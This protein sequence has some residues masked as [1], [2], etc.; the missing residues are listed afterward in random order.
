MYLG[1]LIQD[2][3]LV[4]NAFFAVHHIRLYLSGKLSLILPLPHPR[5]CVQSVAWV[6]DW[7]WHFHWNAV[8]NG[9]QVWVEGQRSKGVSQQF[10][11]RQKHSLFT[12][13]SSSSPCSSFFPL[14]PP[15]TLSLSLPPTLSLSLML[16]PLSAGTVQLQ[17]T[18]PTSQCLWDLHLQVLHLDGHS[19]GL[20]Q[21]S[22]ARYVLS[23]F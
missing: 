14:P 8:C 19:L 2:V 21:G 18:H 20:L 13:P 5:S 11:A 22:H 17:H 16:I 7:K 15:P 1:Q 10:I 9:R 12:P 23:H 3:A 4:D 6:A